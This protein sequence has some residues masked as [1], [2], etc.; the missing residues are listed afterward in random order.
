MRIRSRTT[1][2][3]AFW[4]APSCPGT[5][6]TGA[7]R[8]TALSSAIQAKTTQGVVRRIPTVIGS[9]TPLASDSARMTAASSADT[10]AA[11]GTSIARKR[12]AEPTGQALI[13]SIRSSSSRKSKRNPAH[14]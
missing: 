2:R 13:T 12:R 9:S 6:R 1:P 8:N 4:S 7:N 3:P 14:R 10:S 11:S 5:K